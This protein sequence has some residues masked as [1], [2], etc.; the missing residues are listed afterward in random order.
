MQRTG[1]APS[2]MV[3]AASSGKAVIWTGRILSALAVLPMLGSAIAKLT[4]NAQAI[5]GLVRFGYAENLAT[6]LGIVEITCAVVYL[7][8][9][10]AVLGAILIA[11]YFG[12]AIA[13][14]LRIGDKGFFTPGLFALLAWFALWLRDPR[15]GEV[16]P[17]RRLS[18]PASV[19]R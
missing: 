1:A 14:M 15:L 6:P 12:G 7:I 9:Q 10:T 3:D 4:H 17:L 5:H 2:Q 18:K 8:P 16:L 13:T 11:A 19:P